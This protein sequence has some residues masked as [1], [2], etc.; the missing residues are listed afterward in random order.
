MTAT[1]FVKHPDD[2]YSKADPQPILSTAKTA[3]ELELE[4]LLRCA[5]AIAV[6]K[7]VNTAWYRFAES[8]QKLGIGSVTAR[9]Y[10]DDVTMRA[11]QPQGCAVRG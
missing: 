1:Y 11:P 6:R 2:T 7:G 5:H 3:R 10:Y 8:I 4:E 9:H